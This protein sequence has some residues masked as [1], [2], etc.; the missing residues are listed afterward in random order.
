ME[1][2]AKTGFAGK[3]RARSLC[4]WERARLSH[5]LFDFD[6]QRI[7]IDFQM[8]IDVVF[9]L[10]LFFLPSLPL[11]NCRS[12]WGEIPSSFAALV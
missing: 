3:E 7:V 6:R 5:D 8:P 12:H 4:V 11:S 2:A 10:D 1:I 9:G